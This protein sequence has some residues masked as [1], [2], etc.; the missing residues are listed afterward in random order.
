M[1]SHYFTVKV[2]ITNEQISNGTYGS[3]NDNNS[4]SVALITVFTIFAVV[5][6][7]IIS[8]VAVLIRKQRIK[9]SFEV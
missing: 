5:I 1:Y 4:T 8:I 9:K 3:T 6:M 7:I 2:S